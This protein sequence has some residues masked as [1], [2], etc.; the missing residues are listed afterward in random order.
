METD[1]Y[2]YIYANSQTHEFYQKPLHPDVWILQLKDG[3]EDDVGVRFGSDVL[4]GLQH[5]YQ[6]VKYQ[7][8]KQLFTVKM[9]KNSILS[10]PKKNDNMTLQSVFPSSH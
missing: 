8:V 7:M 6:L 9:Y 2:I 4:Q 3:V 5:T 10:K 1:I